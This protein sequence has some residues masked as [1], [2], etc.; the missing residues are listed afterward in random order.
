MYFRTRK[1]GLTLQPLLKIDYCSLSK[2]SHT[3]PCS[4]PY[5]YKNLTIF[6]STY[7]VSKFNIYKDDYLLS[8][9]FDM[10]VKRTIDVPEMC[11]R[12]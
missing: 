3:D 10:E 4:L 6:R 11:S 7:S 1:D 5:E 9:I 2:W 12:F 8:S